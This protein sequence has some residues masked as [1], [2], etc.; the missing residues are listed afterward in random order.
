MLLQTYWKIEISD[1]NMKELHKTVYSMEHVP[2]LSWRSFLN[3]GSI[4][5]N[6]FSLKAF[7]FHPFLI[8]S[9]Y[10]LYNTMSLLYLLFES[11][12]TVLS[13]RVSPFANKIVF[14][15]TLSFI[16]T[17]SQVWHVNSNL[18]NLMLLLNFLDPLNPKR[19]WIG[20]WVVQRSFPYLLTWLNRLKLVKS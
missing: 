7:F 8:Y 11:F 2:P 12:F 5:D 18:L 15:L 10:K 1:F 4:N 20:F 17:F 3:K 9:L 6:F 14:S 13:S 16:D 19:V